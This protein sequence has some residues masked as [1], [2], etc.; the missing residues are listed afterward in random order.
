M[1]N[2]HFLSYKVFL[3][4][5]KREGRILTKLVFMLG[6]YLIGKYSKKESNKY[7]LEKSFSDI[8]IYGDETNTQEY[9]TY[10]LY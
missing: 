7:L 6:S 2:L 5:N 4:Y 3:I 10:K 8:D 1:L 9:E